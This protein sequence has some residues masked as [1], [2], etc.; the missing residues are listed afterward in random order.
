MTAISQDSIRQFLLA[1]YAEQLTGMGLDPA[2]IED[3]FDFLLQG[4]VDSFGILE[5]VSSIEDEFN[6]ELDLGA[7][8]AE[9]MTILGPLTRFVAENARPK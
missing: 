7:L 9:Q 8:D 3:D 6:V 2:Q 1:K 4:V 5:M